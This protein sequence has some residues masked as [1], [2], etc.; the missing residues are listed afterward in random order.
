MS[1]ADTEF[2]ALFTSIWDDEDTLFEAKTQDVAIALA[3]AV[4]EA[5]L[6]RAELAKK[7]E[8]KPSRVTKV[9][10]GS[11][12]LTLKTIFQVCQAIGLEFDV[13]LRNPDERTEVVDPV[14]FKTINEE[15]INNLH[16]SQQLLDSV[17]QLHMKVSQQALATRGY[18]RE[19]ARLTLVA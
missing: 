12:N 3:S 17:A 10:T 2:S 19:E 15:A 6:S 4:E 13:V 18:T 9:L 1:A 16:K 14:R 5:G 11:S 8:W 7:L